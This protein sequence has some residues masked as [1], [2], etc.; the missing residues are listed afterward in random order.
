MT[1]EARGISG[2]RRRNPFPS[3]NDTEYELFLLTVEKCVAA[4]VEKAMVNYRQ[5]NCGPHLTSTEHLKT[6]VFGSTER[7]IVGL[8]QRM[9]ENEK[10]ATDNATAISDL[11]GVFAKFRWI[12]YTGVLLALIGII[13]A[14]VQAA[15][16]GK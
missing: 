13:A 9:S 3:L 11:L 16:I 4:G 8:D 15:I 12:I 1:D 2:D 6:T 14:I 7:G 5:D 10:L